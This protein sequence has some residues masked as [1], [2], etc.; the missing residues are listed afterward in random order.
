MFLCQNCR[1]ELPAHARAC[2][3]CGYTV[4]PAPA[5]QN[6]EQQRPGSPQVVPPQP[7]YPQP[8]PITPILTQ[9]DT[10]QPIKSPSTPIPPTRPDGP[11][12]KQHPA[13]QKFTLTQRYVSELPTTVIPK[14]HNVAP[15]LKPS[16]EKTP[17]PEQVDRPQRNTEQRAARVEIVRQVTAPPQSIKRPSELP[18]RPVAGQRN[19]LVLPTGQ[20]SAI[21]SIL[22]Q[23]VPANT[24]SV[25]RTRR[26]SVHRQHADFWIF[27][28]II[29]CLICALGLYIFSVAHKP[30]RSSAQPTIPAQ[31]AAVAPSHSFTFQQRK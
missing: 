15:E 22:R 3:R 10:V 1:A 7:N 30:H 5:A 26:K 20:A 12:K 9:Q 25:I 24:Q 16:G 6:S 2:Y 29:L 31:L 19:P 17:V 11:L 13:L 18:G 28:A 23:A 4:S 27:F 21:Q 14:A 8:N